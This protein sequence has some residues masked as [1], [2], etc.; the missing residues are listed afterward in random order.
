M[1]TEDDEEEAPTLVSIDAEEDEEEVTFFP[2]DKMLHEQV[3]SF[4]E[5]HFFPSAPLSRSLGMSQARWFWVWAWVESL[6]LEDETIAA[7]DRWGRIRGV[8][9]GKQTYRTGDMAWWEKVA[10]FWWGEGWEEWLGGLLWRLAWYLRFLLPNY[11]GEHTHGV[12]SRLL[13]RLNYDEEEMMEKMGGC[14]LYSVAILCVAKGG[15]GRGL[16]ARLAREGEARALKRGCDCAA[17]VV[18][19]AHSTRIF[20]KLG[21]STMSEVKHQDF[22][23]GQGKQI[24][25]DTSSHDRVSVLI[26]D[27]IHKLT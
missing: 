18:S 2:V 8:V 9:I 1:D 13:A 5:E 16:G 14:R 15:R 3:H 23:D 6:L 21:F 10:D 26:K 12:F 4:L 11:Y 19:S 25:L 27:K 24:F 17:V 7:L 20:K 22:R